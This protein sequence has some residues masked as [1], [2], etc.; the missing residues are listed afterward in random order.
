MPS[1]PSFVI[2]TPAGF[3][4]AGVGLAVVWTAWEA[5]HW[6]LTLFI[7]I[8]AL[9]LVLGHGSEIGGQFSELLGWTGHKESF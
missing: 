7:L 9:G 3:I 6:F 5:S 2:S 4:L 8:I 1:L